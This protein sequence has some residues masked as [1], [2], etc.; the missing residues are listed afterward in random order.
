VQE[1]RPDGYLLVDNP[2][3]IR[4]FR[5]NCGRQGL[6]SSDFRRRQ[7]AGSLVYRVLLAN[8]GL[9]HYESILLAKRPIPNPVIGH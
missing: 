6:K 8:V 9:T 1:D 7:C 3:G 4:L 5:A 2:I